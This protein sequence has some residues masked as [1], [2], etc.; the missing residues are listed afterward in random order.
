MADNLRIVET[1][2]FDDDPH[3]LRIETYEVQDDEVEVTDDLIIDETDIRPAPPPRTKLED[4][5][6]D[7]PDNVSAQEWEN[8]LEDIDRIG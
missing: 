1:E 3:F 2:L 5:R 7:K 8:L 6:W 4:W